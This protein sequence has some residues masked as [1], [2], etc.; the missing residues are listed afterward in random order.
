MKKNFFPVALMALAIGF[1]ACSS[2]DVVN[3]NGDVVSGNV[4]V[5]E[6]GYVKMAIN[7]PSE[8]SSR[9]SN[10]NNDQFEDGLA[11]EYQVKNATLIL[12]AGDGAN[13]DGAIFHSA[14]NLDKISLAKEG[15]QITSTMRIVKPVNSDDYKDKNTL[16]AYVIL[17]KNNCVT[18][19]STATDLKLNLKLPSSPTTPTTPTTPTSMTGVT[20][21][22]FRQALVE[23]GESGF[24]NDGFLMNNAPLSRTADGKK[25]Y[26]GEVNSPLKMT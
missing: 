15:A 5:L 17:N 3:T 26:E 10:S 18:L 9:A 14:Y 11:N 12:F 23:G 24:K 25:Y 21:G 8:P 22:Q 7:M 13:E 20:F 19:G 2:D 1:N 4:A 6:G 16:Y